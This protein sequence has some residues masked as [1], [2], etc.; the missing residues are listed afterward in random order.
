VYNAA[1]AAAA[2]AADTAVLLLMLPL[3]YMFHTL[4][5][6]CRVPKGSVQTSQTV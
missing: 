6:S 1:A 2:A 4:P 3:T 5:L